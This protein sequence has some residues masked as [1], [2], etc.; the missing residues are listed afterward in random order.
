ML[1]LLL[2]VI[3]VKVRLKNTALYSLLTKFRNN[4]TSDSVIISSKF[5]GVYYAMFDLDNNDK[6]DL[7][8]KIYSSTPYAIFSKVVQITIGDF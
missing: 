7:F 1:P 4:N 6:Y 2:V 3:Q 5:N 8:K